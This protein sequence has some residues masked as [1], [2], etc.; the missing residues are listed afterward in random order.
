MKIIQKAVLISGLLLISAS[1]VIA[2]EKPEG[3][4]F[5]AI[6]DA[7][8]NLQEQINNIQLLPGPQGEKGEKGDTGS[9]GPQ[10]PAGEPSWDE[11][12]IAALEARVAE[13]EQA[14]FP[15]TPPQ[16]PIVVDNFNSYTD[17]GIVGQ[18]GWEEY[19]N[20]NNFIVQETSVYEGTKALYNN[21]TG[22][23]V[24]NKQGNSLPSGRQAFYIKTKDRSNWGSYPNGNAQVRLLKWV[25]EGSELRNFVAV[26][27]KSDGNVAY[28]NGS[29]YQ[30]FATYS[31]NEW[32]LLEIEWRSNDKTAKYR[33][34]N[35]TWTDWYAIAGSS[36]FTDFD[37]VGF[38]FNLPNGSGG[39]YFDNLY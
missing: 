23:S 38:D 5:K 1:T 27:F 21:S 16:S 28:Y 6:W 22:D 31:D 30:N 32:T 9:Q 15:P 3:N 10:G 18:G 35:G 26:S 11:Q 13:L 24:I 2:S 25:W 4:P 36:S 34:N 20:G 14:V 33:I 12:R 37:H 7:V 17:G 29:A 19:K 8:N 39:V